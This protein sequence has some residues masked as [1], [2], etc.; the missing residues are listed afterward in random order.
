MRRPWILAVAA[1]AFVPAASAQRG[2]SIMFEEQ[3]PPFLAS[4]PSDAEDECARMARELEEL[5]GKPQ[6][7]YGLWQRYAAECQGGDAAPPVPGG[8]PGEP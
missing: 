1:L 6:R 5:K 7:R 4:P 8:E 2:E 3:P